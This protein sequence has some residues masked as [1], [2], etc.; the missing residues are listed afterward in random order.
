MKKSRLIFY[1]IFAL[2]HLFLFF[3]SLYVDSNKNDIQF[4]LSLQGKIWL[5]KYG[6]FLGLALLAIDLLWDW[7]NA[8]NHTKEK[9]LLAHEI[10]TLK[11]K[12]FDMQEASRDTSLHKIPEP[13]EKH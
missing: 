3:F 8:R 13:K 10:N 9:D 4:L 6:S 11:A 7:Q 2:F 5:L 12:L 1:A